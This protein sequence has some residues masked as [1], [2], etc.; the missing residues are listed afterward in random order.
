MDTLAVGPWVYIEPWDKFEIRETS[1]MNGLF[2][3]NVVLH[4]SLAIDFRQNRLHPYSHLSLTYLYSYT[5]TIY[6]Q[7]QAS[8][9]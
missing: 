6:Q 4:V 5:E 3:V 9:E 7:Q 2:S 8:T 1:E